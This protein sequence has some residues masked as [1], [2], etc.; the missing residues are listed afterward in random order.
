[1][2]T[3]FSCPKK[4]YD[5]KSCIQETL[6][7]LTN[8]NRSGGHTDRRTNVQE[9][10]RKYIWAF[11]WPSYSNFNATKKM[12]KNDI[13]LGI[14]TRTTFNLQK[15]KFWNGTDIQPNR[16]TKTHRKL[17]QYVFFCNGLALKILYEPQNYWPYMGFRNMDILPTFDQNISLN[18]EYYPE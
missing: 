12:T 14:L 2:T 5:K 6:N 9:L 3:Y 11:F 15:W 18:G 7:F 10:Q 8:W 4:F 1:M 17:D 16:Q 13:F